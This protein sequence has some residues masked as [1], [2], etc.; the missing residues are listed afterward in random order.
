LSIKFHKNFLRGSQLV[1]C[2]RTDGHGETVSF[3]S[4]GNLLKWE[5][6]SHLEYG[7]LSYS[8]KYFMERHFNHFSNVNIDFFELHKMT[9]LVQYHL[10][11]DFNDGARNGDDTGAYSGCCNIGIG[12]SCRS[13]FTELLCGI[14]SVV[15]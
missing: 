5:K 15:I 9:P 6:S 8:R 2:G 14:S 3:R 11:W 10:K 4:F 12:Y 13:Y 7:R 1:L